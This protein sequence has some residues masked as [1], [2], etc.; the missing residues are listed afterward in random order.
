MQQNK[1]PTSGSELGIDTWSPSVGLAVRIRGF[2]PLVPGSTP[3]LWKVYDRSSV[4]RY[5]ELGFADCTL[6][7]RVRHPDWEKFC[8]PARP[9]INWKSTAMQQNKRP[10][11]ES[12]L[13]IEELT[14][15]VGLAVRIF[16]F[17]PQAPSSTL[18]LWT[19]LQSS[20]GRLLFW[21]R[22]NATEQTIKMRI[23]VRDWY[24]NTHSWSS[25]ED[26][27]LSPKRPG[28]NSRTGKHFEGEQR[29]LMR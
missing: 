27:W 19:N 2:R 5:I 13:R 14:V 26:L 16:G 10:T 24:V 7:S 3:G 1:Q 21:N 29:L 23:R 9:F 15:P 25:G 28:F 18:G 6:K 22:F 8:K 12:E 17:H 20:K 4:S 11:T